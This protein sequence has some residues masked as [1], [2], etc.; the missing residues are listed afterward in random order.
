MR[1]IVGS[2]L[3]NISGLSLLIAM[4]RQAKKENTPG[5]NLRCLVIVGCVLMFPV[6]A[7]QTVVGYVDRLTFLQ[8]HPLLAEIV[9]SGIRLAFVEEICKYWGTKIVTWKGEYFNNSRQGMLF[10]AITALSFGLLEN[11]L[12]I[13]LSLTEPP[14]QFWLIVLTR[15]LIGAPGHGAYGIIMGIF[16]WRAKNAERVGN[17]RIKRKNLCLAT[18]VPGSI[19]GIYDWLASSQIIKIGDTHIVT[20]IMVILDFLVIIF[21]YAL[22]YRRKTT[23]S[24]KN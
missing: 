12:F 20:I 16:Y 15:A 1:M 22:L 3:C 18:L 17:Q 7:L 5:K 23:V 10:P 6:I 24:V 8:T 14:R 13:A 21:A 9:M 19:H 11:V 2:I 4:W